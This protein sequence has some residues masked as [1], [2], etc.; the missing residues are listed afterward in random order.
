VRLRGVRA[1]ARSAAGPR[2]D[3]IRQRDPDMSPRRALVTGGSGEIGAAICRRL[4]QEGHHVYVHARRGAE[5]AGKLVAEI[6]AAGG[7]AEALNFDITDA[8][9]TERA[10]E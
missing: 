10:L 6:T 9:E 7:H 5:I 1:R 4:A 2:D 8:Q 3:S